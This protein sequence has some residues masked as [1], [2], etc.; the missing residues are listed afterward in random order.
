MD[1]QA[2]FI[3]SDHPLS[4][5]VPNRLTHLFFFDQVQIVLKPFVCRSDKVP[6]FAQVLGQAF[7]QNP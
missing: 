6:N 1:L 3:F 2:S 5:A 4:H 7:P